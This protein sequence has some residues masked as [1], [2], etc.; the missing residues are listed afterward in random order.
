MPDAHH[1]AIEMMADHGFTPDSIEIF[2]LLIDFW[3]RHHNLAMCIQELQS[4][5]DK[6]IAP[7]LKIINPIVIL[8]AEEGHPR[9]AIDLIQA[10]ESGET[11]RIPTSVWAQVL[12]T[13]ATH[14]YV[15]S[16]RVLLLSLAQKTDSFI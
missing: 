2:E 1:A 7:T 16:C 11:E 8:A 15:C 6:D 10:Y 12:L 3:A 13:S 14:S 4:L 9:L 5:F